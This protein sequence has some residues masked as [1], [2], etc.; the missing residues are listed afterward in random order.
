[1]HNFQM[2]Y[3]NDRRHVEYSAP[4]NRWFKLVD[5]ISFA[6]NQNF[7]YLLISS[8]LNLLGLVPS[9]NSRIFIKNENEV[10]AGE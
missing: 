2:L 1:M 5:I 9:I 6:E 7:R 8:V 3:P 10:A 4:C